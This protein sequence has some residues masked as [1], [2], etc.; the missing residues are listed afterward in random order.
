VALSANR[1]GALPAYRN[2]QHPGNS[3]CKRDTSRIT[4]QLLR[5][6][7]CIRDNEWP[8]PLDY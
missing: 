7:P 4:P 1:T 2:P 6:R 5:K 8:I 3:P